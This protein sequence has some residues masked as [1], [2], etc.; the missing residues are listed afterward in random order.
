MKIINAV[1]KIFKKEIL[2][3]YCLVKI[4]IYVHKKKCCAKKRGS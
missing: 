3:S 1:Q 2:F 4:N